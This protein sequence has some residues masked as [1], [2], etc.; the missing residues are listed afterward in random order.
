MCHIKVS[1]KILIINMIILILIIVSFLGSK[2]KNA[3]LRPRLT[4]Y[5]EDTNR[6][7]AE[8]SQNA[9]NYFQTEVNS[10]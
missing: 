4:C 1:N 2:G 8:L 10:E 5:R 3:W 9:V 6:Y 7:Y